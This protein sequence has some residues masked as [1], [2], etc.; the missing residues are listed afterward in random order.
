MLIQNLVQVNL[1]GIIKQYIQEKSISF[2]Q[3][4]PPLR[5]SLT[6]TLQ[7]PSIFSDYELSWF[8]RMSGT[9]RV[10]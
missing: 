9:S 3:I 1:E 2:G 7:G 5:L 10:S 4:L 8:I 6:G